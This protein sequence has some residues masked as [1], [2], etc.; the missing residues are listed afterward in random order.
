MSTG[1]RLSRIGLM[2]LLC[3][4][5]SLAGSSAFAQR[6]SGGSNTSG[7]G[8]G[9]SGGFSG[10]NASRGFSGGG[11]AR[12]FSP[13][14]GASASTG[15]RS[16]N[17]SRAL[18]NF[19]SSPNF[20]SAR[21]AVQNQFPNANLGRAARNFANSPSS[22]RGFQGLRSSPSSNRS[23]SSPGTTSGSAR[24]NVFRYLGTRDA[25]S[26][27]GAAS[28]PTQGFSSLRRGAPAAPLGGGSRASA[29]AVSGVQRGFAGSTG[30]STGLGSRSF[31]GVR[32]SPSAAGGVNRGFASRGSFGGRSVAG[33]ISSRR[34]ARAVTGF[35]SSARFGSRGLGER[36]SSGFSAPRG[37][38]RDSF[39]RGR[40]GDWHSGWHHDDW[41]RHDGHFH[42]FH[43]SR[44]H[45]SVNFFV[46][47]GGFFWGDWW[48]GS[49][50]WCDP[51]W[52][53]GPYWPP[54]Y[55]YGFAAYYPS[56]V[57]VPV[58]YPVYPEGA[59]ASAGVYTSPPAGGTYQRSDDDKEVKETVK[60]EVNALVL[61]DNAF[62]SGDYSKAIE[63]YEQAIV[64]EPGSAIARF[65]LGEALFVKG[66]YAYAAFVL[67]KGLEL[68]GSW[69]DVEVTK[70]RVYG[71]LAD[72]ATALNKLET[73]VASHPY[74]GAAKFV[75]GYEY[76]VTKQYDRAK[77]MLEQ[78]RQLGPDPAADLILD[79]IE[80]R[81]APAAEPAPEKSDKKDDKKFVDAG[82]DGGDT[83]K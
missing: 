6:S 29:P 37:A 38:S 22:P 76:F 27:G 12:S 13:S 40:D 50:L 1:S 41:G 35:D 2:G 78:A 45:F 62:R 51:W 21:S 81:H 11:G 72:Y 33:G 69:L 66:D 48:F 83:G 17:A 39:G 64:L 20:G 49:P 32:S 4:A 19:R 61:G 15:Q 5:T 74:D 16:F 59:P 3:V 34:D 25:G 65:A 63:E 8:G 57:Y 53:W 54:Y 68:D 71:K 67:R 44:F 46:G 75:L 79:A 70:D 77:E 14:R 55:G 23:F 60:P 52:S 9:R 10:G 26:S 47:F 24:S 73:F 36:F 56:P 30:R 28:Q 82:E 43:H 18:S 58:Y 31:D 80:K 42:D 7:F